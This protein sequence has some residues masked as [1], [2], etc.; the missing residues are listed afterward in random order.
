MYLYGLER[1]GDLTSRHLIGK[2]DWYREGAEYLLRR[3]MVSGGWG[4][5]ILDTCFA[6]LFLKRSTTPVATTGLVR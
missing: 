1:V 3:Q 6:L 5:G 4:G 2:H